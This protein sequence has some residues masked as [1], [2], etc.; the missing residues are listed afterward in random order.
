CSKY[1]ILWNNSCIVDENVKVDLIIANGIDISQQRAIEQDQQLLYLQ[2]E[3]TFQEAVWERDFRRQ[4]IETTN[5]IFIIFDENGF[6]LEFN[7][8]AEKISGYK[9]EEVIGERLEILAPQDSQETVLPEFLKRMKAGNIVNQE[10]QWVTKS[11]KIVWIHW[12]TSKL[13]HPHDDSTILIATGIDITATKEANQNLSIAYTDL[14][15]LND[16]LEDRVKERTAALELANQELEG[17]SYSVSHD[18]RAPLRHILGFID[19]IN[20]KITDQFDPQIKRYI[21]IVGDSAKR[22]GLLIDELLQFSRMGRVEMHQRAVDLNSMIPE[23]IEELNEEIGDREIEWVIRS[24]P[25]VF[26]DASMIFLVFQNLISNAIKF[27]RN[28]DKPKI[29]IFSVKKNGKVEIHI[30][31]NGVGFD[32]QYADKLFGVFQRLHK[33]EDFEGTGIGLANVK[34]IIGRHGGQ[35]SFHAEIDQGADFFFILKGVN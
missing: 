7:L 21:D 11:G 22:L 31:D 25:H 8:S 27:T 12:A 32:M 18:L 14:K 23:V 33:I 24:L 2:L 5:A 30:K 3:H 35:V 19:L 28:V 4:I 16:H 26:G 17:F 15:E 10:R 6:I 29:E 20:M 9:R 13:T 34:R 1:L